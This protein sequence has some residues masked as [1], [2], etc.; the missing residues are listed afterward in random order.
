MNSQPKKAVLYRMVMPGHTCP[1]GLKSLALLKRK[2][3]A[4]EDRHLTTKE[5]TEAFKAEHNVRT[6]PQTFIE[7]ERIGGNDDLHRHFGI[8]V[9]DA[10][11]VS[12]VPVLAVFTVAALIA[13]AASWAAL[14]TLASET[15]LRWFLAVTTVILAMLKLQDVES[16]SS[17]FLNYDVLAKRWVPYSYIYPYA[18]LLVGVLMIA[19]ALWWLA[20][21][22]AIVIG[23]IGAWSVFK[24]V[25]IEKRSIKCACV[26]GSSKVPLGFVSLT[27]NVMMVA[28]AIWMIC[29]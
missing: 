3:Y 22:V 1:F 6:T 7:G 4:V 10:N 2:G 21:P 5:E 24:A 11:S 9:R 13:L 8:K 12:Y 28:I 16:F 27:E 18:E 25:Y 23:G 20:S 26:G 14:G 29:M 19:G 15:T 17:M